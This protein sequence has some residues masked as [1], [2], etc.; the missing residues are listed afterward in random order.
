M[1]IVKAEEKMSSGPLKM[2][3]FGPPGVGKTSTA[4]T[5]SRPITFDF[6]RGAHR[7]AFRK[8]TVVIDNMQEVMAVKKEDLDGYDTIIIDTA[9]SLIDYMINDI[10]PMNEGKAKLKRPSG[11]PTLLGYGRL[12]SEFE[13]F[14][15]RL[16]TFG[17][18]IIMIAHDKEERD[19]EARI[20][21][22]DIVG[23]ARAKILKTCDAIGYMNFDG[24]KK[25]LNF[26]PSETTIGKDC[27]Q[28]GMLEVPNF[29]TNADWFATVIDRIKQSLEDQVSSNQQI[30]AEWN[31]QKDKLEQHFKDVKDLEGFNKAFSSMPKIDKQYKAY[32]W[33][34]IQELA[35]M[36]GFVYDKSAKE[37]TS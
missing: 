2:M 6:D 19:G 20:V 3:I 14:F 11:N 22:P 18:D 10:L 7:S 23:G 31:K 5:A 30:L 32:V 35:E 1:K 25:Y 36:H 34:F 24:G 13:F 16:I 17:K 21:R 27:A 28:I 9:G 12:K 4:N 26:S 15:N 37:F 29:V 8:D 33:S